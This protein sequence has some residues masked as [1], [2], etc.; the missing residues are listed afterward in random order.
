MLFVKEISSTLKNHTEK[1]VLGP[2]TLIIGP[3]R[4]GKSAIVNALELA[5]TGTVSDLVGRPLVKE[6]NR[7]LSLARGEAGIMARALIGDDSDTNLGRLQTVEVMSKGKKMV[8]TSQPSCYNPVSV[9]PLRQVREALAGNPETTRRFFIQFVAGAVTDEDVRNEIPGPLQAKY[10]QALASTPKAA[11]VDALLS[12]L[13]TTKER[14]AAINADLKARAAIVAE[15]GA[16]LAAPP[17]HLALAAAQ[18]KVDKLQDQC[19][20]LEADLVREE[21]RENIRQQFV[22]LRSRREE[23]EHALDEQRA[24]LAEASKNWPAPPNEADTIRPMHLALLKFA[25]KRNETKC[26]TCQQALGANGITEFGA[27]WSARVAKVE[28]AGMAAAEKLR[29]F[30]QHKALVADL[31]NEIDVLGVDHAKV[32][33]QLEALGVMP[34][35]LNMGDFEQGYGQMK[36]DLEAARNEVRKLEQAKASWEPI[37]RARDGSVE[38]EAE[39]AEWARL[40][41]AISSAIGGLLDKA[42]DAFV[43]RVQAFLPK[44]DVFGLTL[45]DED[46]EVCQYGLVREGRLQEA[47]SGVEWAYVTAAIA[48]AA[49]PDAE[50]DRLHVVV[51]EDRA[52]DVDTLFAVCDA[53]AKLNAQVIIATT[54]PAAW[55]GHAPAGWALV[56][57]SDSDVITHKASAT[58]RPLRHEQPGGPHGLEDDERNRIEVERLAKENERLADEIKQMKEEGLRAGTMVKEL[59]VATGEWRM[60][61]AAPITPLKPADPAVSEAAPRRGRPR[62][63]KAAPMPRPDLPPELE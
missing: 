33:S 3:N 27:F 22:A 23:I 52:W 45:R 59:D 53:M 28:A 13:S 42:R 15:A 14:I 29:V 40:A 7:L 20:D 34:E 62:K 32:E 51:Y 47:L 41:D 46:H 58:P 36:A 43:A 2:K 26:P 6:V 63:E 21:S 18:A 61:P 31:Q 4:A 55:N 12:A 16:G 30:E 24:A 17:S 37:K 35:P 56:D 8:W 5:L 54:P 11:P 9:F 50:R 44:G 48:A 39:K 49:I 10:Q 25:Q 60:R 57:L 19:R 38:K 1:T